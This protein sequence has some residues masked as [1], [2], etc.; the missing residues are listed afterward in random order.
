MK[1][2]IALIS[3]LIFSIGLGLS[4][5]TRPDVVRGFLDIF[6]EWNW[7]LMGVMMGAIG[8]HGVAY[9][10]ITKRQRP[11]LADKFDLPVKNTVDKKLLVG[12]GLFGL[13]WGWVGIC[14]GPGIVSLASGDWSIFYFVISMLVGIKIAQLFSKR[15]L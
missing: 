6:G 8:V 12:A 14:P 9:Y 5:M 3:G 2:T 10:F 7:S 11:I 13:G 15:S 1:N 4:G